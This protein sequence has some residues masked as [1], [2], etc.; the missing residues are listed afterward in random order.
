M[1]RYFFILCLFIGLQPSFAQYYSGVSIPDTTSQVEVD[2]NELS[3][4]L[5]Q[6]IQ[7]EDLEKHLSILASHEFQGRETGTIGAEKAA[8]YIAS[9]FKNIGIPGI[10]LENSHF[11]NV[12]FT[13]SKWGSCKLRIDS[14]DYRHLKDYISLPHRNDGLVDFSS[15]EVIFLGFGIDD[16]NYSDYKGAK[17]RDKIILIYQGEPMT[18]D[19]IYWVSKSNSPSEWSTNMDLKLKAAKNHGAALVLIIEPDIQAKLLSERRR[20]LSPVMELGNKTTELNPL[21][22][23]IYI[24]TSMAREIIGKKLKKV[25]KSRDRSHKKGKACDVK[26]KQKLFVSQEK[27]VT[28]LQSANVLGYI[29]GSDKREELIILTAHY[30][31]LGIRGEDNIYFG[32]NDNAS[33]TVS[34]MEIAEALAQAKAAGDGPRRSVLCLLVTGEEKGLLGSEYYTE[35]PMF[36]L[37]NTI[38]NVNIDMVGRSDNYHEEDEEYIYVIGSDRIS[39]DLHRIHQEVNNKYTRILL[40]YT[41]NAKND[42]NQYYSR[43]DHYNFAIHG[44]PSIFFYN[45]EHNDYHRTTDTI[46]KMNFNK[47][48]KVCRLIFHTTWEL[49]NREETIKKN[50]IY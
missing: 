48:E 8:N 49:A 43:S 46:E 18:K 47:L 31:H 40:D 22:N 33:G 21:A 13:W 5:A 2:S 1:I 37:E 20:L 11:Q 45:G 9:H 6:T 14:T 25:S 17:V 23:S 26:L 4:I 24:N 28:L 38:A 41:Y 16:P 50:R 7:K 30:D 32:A 44:I 42:P 27:V 15:E 10:G 3:Y 34:V 35:N 12:A 39:A 29:E 36:P 19:S